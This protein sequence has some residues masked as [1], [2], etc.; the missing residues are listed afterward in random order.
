MITATHRAHAVILTSLAMA[1]ILTIIPLPGWLDPL[2]PE[3]VALGLIYWCMALPNR[4]GV[5]IAWT[6]GLFLDVLRGGLL[7]Q[8][9]LTLCLIVYIALKFYRRIRVAPLWQ[10]SVSIF[11]L[12]LIHLLLNLW[13]KGISG[14]PPHS[15]DYWFP[16]FTSMLIWPLCF[17][18]L[19]LMR[20]HFRI[21]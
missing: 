7:G 8:H 19:R 4:V 1:F 18:G 15:W 6:T 21:T 17:L 11:I 12:M 2:R 14:Q 10:Q 16:A 9:A 13:I 20:R 5:G 3:W